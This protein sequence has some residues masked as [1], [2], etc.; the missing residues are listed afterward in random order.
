MEEL[1]LTGTISTKSTNV[2]NGL[3][4]GLIIGLVYCVSIFLRFNLL[5]LG[6]IMV[7]VIT[8][9]FYCIVIGLLVFCGVKRRK[10]LGG[11]IELKD[12]FQT[13]FVAV[14]IGEFIYLLFN[15]IYMKYIEPDYLDKFMRSM[16]KWIENSPMSDTKK[17]ETLD[18]I[19]S[20][21]ESQKA[22]GVTFKGAALSYLISVC[23]TGVIGFIIALIIR[24]R[25]PVFDTP[26]L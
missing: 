19:R 25:K 20:S 4:F 15:F 6:P 8:L 13:I 18:K 5:S 3:M 9:L 26:A 2:K 23:V 22:K 7:G 12:A 17:D 1:N 11:Y 14:L 24:K 21:M 16:E 10:E